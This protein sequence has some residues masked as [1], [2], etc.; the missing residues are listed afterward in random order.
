MKKT[1]CTLLA[2]VLLLGGFA[3]GASAT[4]EM[5]DAALHARGEALARETLAV[6]TGDGW[7]IHHSHDAVLSF[8]G[9][10]HTW[11]HLDVP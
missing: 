9:D 3:V 4:Y 5:D 11:N 6:L 8:N 7:T 1:L 2:L 10:W